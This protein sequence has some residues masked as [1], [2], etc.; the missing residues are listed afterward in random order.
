[1]PK[2]IR[3]K[4]VVSLA[5]MIN[6]NPEKKDRSIQRLLMASKLSD[7]LPILYR[8]FERTV[9]DANGVEVEIYKPKNGTSKKLIYLVHGGAFIMNVVASYRDLHAALSKAGN[10]ATVAL[11]QYRTAPK[12]VY[13]AAHD[14]VMTAWNYL[15]GTLG[16][17]AEDVVMIGDSAGGNLVLSTL[18]R[19]RNTHQAMPAAAVVISPWTD[20][21]ATGESYKKNYAVDVIFGKRRGRL[22]DGKIKKLLECGVY[23]YAQGADRSHP[24]LSPVYGEFDNLPPILMTVG[25]HEMLLDDTLRVAQK[26][27]LAGGQVEV[28]IGEGMFHVYPLFYRVSPT[29]HASFKKILA[30]LNQHTQ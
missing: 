13:P 3:D 17:R 18:L 29:A 1:M 14:D 15:Q 7:F 27:N 19:L 12:H 26:I 23:A 28:E 6:I 10:D 25:S 11:V 4:V 2:R 22:D 5:S 20:L 21:L 9:I 30:F 16:Y 24:Y 8:G